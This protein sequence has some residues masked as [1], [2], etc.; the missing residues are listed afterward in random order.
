[1]IHCRV[2]MSKQKIFP[3]NFLWGASTAGHQVEGDNY[4]NWSVW[5]LE[6]ANEQAKNSHQHAWMP[7]WSEIKQEAENPDNYVS[8]RGVDHYNRYKADFKLLKQLN[9]NSFRFSVEWARIE[10][11]EGKWDEAE[12]QH[13][14]D[15]LK[16]LKAAGITPMLNIW[17][18]THPVWFDKKGAFE[19]KANIKY[20]E[21]FVAKLEPLLKEVDYVVTI[22][23]P[24]NV[25]WFQYI[26]GDWPP[27][28]KGKYWLAFKVYRNLV[29]AHKRAYKVIKKINPR[30]QITSALQGSSNVPANPRNL[31]HKLSAAFANY[32][33]NTWYLKRVNRYHDIIGF[34]YYFKNYV[35]GPRPMLDFVNPKEPVNDLGWYMEPYALIEVLRHISKK[36]KNKPIVVLENGLADRNDTQRQWWL[37]QSMKALQDAR[38]EG[39]NIIGYYHWSLLDNFEWAYGWWPKFGLV[40]VDRKTMKR[41]VRKSA[42]WWASWLAKNK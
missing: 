12:L 13:Y 40:E 31:Y 11:V 6:V 35:K 22:N 39:I 14:I 9:L 36:F 28:H 15:Y 30:S 38:G 26:S 5:E 24:N 32:V 20:F 37:E 18:W 4:N 25:A 19:K 3:K 21:R 17:H 27:A 34:N 1:M 7:V 2:A 29:K 42:I 23:E 10:P 8:G 33:A 16:E 41:R